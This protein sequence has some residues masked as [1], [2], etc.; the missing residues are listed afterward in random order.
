MATSKPTHSEI[1]PEEVVGL[2]A[3]VQGAIIAG[4]DISAILV[5]VTPYSLGIKVVDFR[6]GKILP[7]QY[8]VIIK[9]NTAIPVSKS[10]I[11]STIY[12]GQEKVRV[13]V[14]QGENRTASRNTLLGEF[15]IEGFKPNQ[16]GSNSDFIVTFDFDINGI[17]NVT[18]RNKTTGK[19]ESISIEASKERL[20]EA[21]KEEAKTKIDSLESKET[22]QT[23]QLL[24]K[25]RLVA[26]GMEN[27]D[28]AASLL[29][30]IESIEQ[31]RQQKPEEV[32]ALLEELLDKMY[33]AE[34]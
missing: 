21:Q 22:T 7:D 3:A 13:K 34:K 12:P 6:P 32:E 10:E 24:E 9:R 8:S 33:E 17:L 5:D 23:E 27:Q 4:E 11:Y 15:M 29:N 18:A 31:A 2:G 20:T 16:D 14:Y 1:N 30:L 19:E 26:E 28:D 25:A